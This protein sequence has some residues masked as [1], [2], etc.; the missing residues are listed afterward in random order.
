MSFSYAVNHQ[1]SGLGV[2]GYNRF[3]DFA[4]GGNIALLP[5]KLLYFS[6]EL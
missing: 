2:I 6:R 3:P 1:V 4:H 5:E